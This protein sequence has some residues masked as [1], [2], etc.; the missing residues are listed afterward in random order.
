[1]E[2]KKNV[3]N[4]KRSLAFLGCFL[5]VTLCAALPCFALGG[6]ISGNP[7]SKPYA[8]ISNDWQLTAKGNQGKLSYMEQWAT[9]VTKEQAL[10]QNLVEFVDG[11]HPASLWGISALVDNGGV[12]AY[13]VFDVSGTAYY[14]GTTGSRQFAHI[15]VA[16]EWTNAGMTPVWV[17]INNANR[18]VVD[19][20]I[21]TPDPANNVWSTNLVY[22]HFTNNTPVVSYPNNPNTIS[23][24]L[25]IFG[26]N[27]VSTGSHGGIFTTYGE[28]ENVTPDIGLSAFIDFIFS[29]LGKILTIEFFGWY[30][31]GALIGVFMSISIVLVFLKYFAGG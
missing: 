11:L 7:N 28:Q 23:S 5:L 10:K 1:M 19:I 6:S 12:D 2:N 24:F 4:I 20:L 21:N 29:V 30:T 14:S 9:P 15:V 31:I 16:Y 25:H 13:Q 22:L 17:S 8:N 18:G 27:Y 3:S 26:T